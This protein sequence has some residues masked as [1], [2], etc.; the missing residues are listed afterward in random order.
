[1]KNTKKMTILALYTTIALTIFVI[2][3]A[4]PT[5]V[6]IPGVKLGLANIITLLVLLS[7]GGK[8]AVCVLVMRI[9]LGSIFAGQM[10]SFFYSLCGGLL[11][12]AMMWLVNRILRGKYVYLTSVI[13]AIFHNIGQ[14]LAAIVL[15]HSMSVL[16]YFPILMVS[17]IVTGIFTGL[18]THFAYR[19]L[20]E[21]L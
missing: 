10:M 17:G 19:R 2:E 14:I 3:S 18:C 7:Y 8:E 4:L 16:L 21:I 15:T 11:C 6:P 5:L 13:G 9:V 1:M 12:F 20:Q